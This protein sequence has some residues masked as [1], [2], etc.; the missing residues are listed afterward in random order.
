V[1]NSVPHDKLSPGF[2]YIHIDVKPFYS[3]VE[4]TRDITGFTNTGEIIFGDLVVWSMD[5][6]GN[7][8]LGAYCPDQFIGLVPAP[9][10]AMP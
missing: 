6:E 4:I 7:H 3:I 8:E 9:L 1:R 5:H 10:Q 2:W